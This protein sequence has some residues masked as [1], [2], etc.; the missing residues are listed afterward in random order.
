MKKCT[1]QVAIDPGRWHFQECGNPA[2][3]ETP[4]GP[5]CGV[6][7]PNRPR[8]KAQLA[9]DERRERQKLAWQLDDLA[10]E[11]A[12]KLADGNWS[13]DDLIEQYRALRDR[14]NQNVR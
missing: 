6:H 1:E 9:A 11:I 12:D 2:K 7:N 8:T 5:R 13:V 3:V 10:H 4:N 14:I